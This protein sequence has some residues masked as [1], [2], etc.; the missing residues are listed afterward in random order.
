V[1]S[2]VDRRSTGVEVARLEAMGERGLEHR[3]RGG[4]LQDMGAEEMGLEVT[5]PARHGSRGA[6]EPKRKGDRWR[7]DGSI[8]MGAEGADAARL[9]RA[10]YKTWAQ[11]SKEAALDGA[12]WGTWEQTRRDWRGLGAGHGGRGSEETRLEVTG[13]ETWEQ[14]TRD[15]R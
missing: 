10:S 4:E 13:R 3:S 15:W 5:G 6:G 1:R 8:G 9:D 12:V 2:A 11:R 14:R 7:G